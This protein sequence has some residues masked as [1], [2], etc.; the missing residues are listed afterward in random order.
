MSSARSS[1]EMPAL[2]RRTLAWER[3]SLLKGMS[4]DRL[5]VILGSEAFMG[6]FSVK[7]RSGD[8][9]STFSPVT[10]PLPPSN[11]P[12]AGTAGRR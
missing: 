9:L 4:C 12:P 3:M 11:S 5:R 10:T 6:C 1:T 7:G 8:A 2:I